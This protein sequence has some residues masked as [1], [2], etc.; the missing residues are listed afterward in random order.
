MTHIIQ[1]KNMNLLR[2]FAQIVTAVLN[3]N[4]FQF[5]IFAYLTPRTDA[6]TLWTSFICLFLLPFVIY[7]AYVRYT[8]GRTDYYKLERNKRMLPFLVNIISVIGFY[9]FLSPTISHIA[10]LENA[11]FIDDRLM[12]F[13]LFVNGIS[14]LITLFWRIS[15]HTTA[16]AAFFSMFFVVT[17]IYS[18]VWWVV[19]LVALPAVAWA[20][21]YL[22]AHTPMQILGGCL[23]GIACPFIFSY[24]VKFFS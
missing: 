6:L 1:N 23:L 3:P 22:R 8:L 2:V 5:L 4:L 20:R 16:L 10:D 14:L 18:L 19:C 15:I 7:V 9:Y 21:Y 13:L 24:V 11:H 12:L 17:A